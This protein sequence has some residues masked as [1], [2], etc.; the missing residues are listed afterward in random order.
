[1]QLGVNRPALL[2]AAGEFIQGHPW[3]NLFEGKSTTAAMNAMNLTAMV[4]GNHEFDFGQDV[5]KRRIAE[6]GFPVLAT[7]DPG[8]PPLKPFVIQEIAGLKVA[9]IGLITEETPSTT[10][11]KNVEGLTF[12]PVIETARKWIGELKD[13]ADLV[14]VLS[15]QG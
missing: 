7:T 10:H 5:L 9:M 14:I 13:Q 3:T 6:P 12:S 1:H 4:P 15:H 2:L 8:F 11:P